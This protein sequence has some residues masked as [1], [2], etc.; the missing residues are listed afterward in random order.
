MSFIGTNWPSVRSASMMSLALILLVSAPVVSAVVGAAVS[1]YFQPSKSAVSGIR[2]FAAGVVFAAAAAEILPDVLHGGSP[3]FAT[4]VGGAVGLIL[5]LVVKQAENWISG[6]AGLIV[7]IGIDLLVDG[8]VL[9]VALHAAG[10]AGLLLAIALTIEVLSLGLAI[11]TSLSEHWT[12]R[13]KVVAVVGG[14]ALMLPVGTALATPV[15]FLPEVYFTSILALALVALLYLVTEEL[16]VE[17]HE[18]EDTPLI[19]AMFFAGF[20]GLL[21]LEELM[22]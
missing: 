2:H 14:L 5:M 12:S 18:T 16:L 9:G 15:S 10:T 8:L 11:T 22:G 1:T 19:T 17:A 13:L 3:V 21:V 7:A 6:P 4:I 20:L